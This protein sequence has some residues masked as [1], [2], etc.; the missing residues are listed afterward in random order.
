MFEALN[1][2]SV[3]VM[4][5]VVDGANDVPAPAALDAPLNLSSAAGI[6][7]A[8]LLV[9]QVVHAFLPD[10]QR[11]WKLLANLVVA[12]VL[13]FIFLAD[14]TSASAIATTFIQGL[15]IFMASSG[16]ANLLPRDQGHPSAPIGDQT[17]GAPGPVAGGAKEAE[18]TKP[19]VFKRLFT[20]A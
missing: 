20:S 3:A 11:G 9:G 16:A 13:S 14:G 4:Q 1:S 5:V 6:S 7:A 18:A 2:L 19:G 12:E 8:V 15:Y 10:I 17:G